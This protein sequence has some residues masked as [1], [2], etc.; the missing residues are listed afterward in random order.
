MRGMGDF[1]GYAIPKPIVHA[2]IH[3]GSICGSIQWGLTKQQQQQQLLISEP[4][5]CSCHR[6][7]R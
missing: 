3:L 1:T 7:W 5:L 6:V 2:A 4:M